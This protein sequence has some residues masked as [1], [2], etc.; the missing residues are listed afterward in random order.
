MLLFMFQAKPPVCSLS[1][2]EFYFNGSYQFATVNPRYFNKFECGVFKS[3]ESKTA[4]DLVED[5]KNALKEL[6]D[7]PTPHVEGTDC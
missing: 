5:I 3:I 7:A 1:D 6:N 4:E 2:L